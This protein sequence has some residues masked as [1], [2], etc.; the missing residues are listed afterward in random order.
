[1]FVLRS[2]DL[3][4]WA[5][6]VRGPPRY[7][8]VAADIW[9][10]RR[11]SQ[12]PAFAVYGSPPRELAETPAGA[13]QLSP[14]VPGAAA[15]EELAPG[16]LEAIV[17]AAP[18]GTIERRYVLALALRA[19]APGGRLTALAPKDKG[20]SRLGKELAAFGCTVHETPKRRQRICQTRRPDAPEGLDAAIEAGRPRLSDALGL[21]TWPGVFSWDRPDPGSVLLIQ[22]LPPLSGRGAD[23]GCGIGL[24][25]R[26]VL[27]QPTVTGLALVELDRRAIEC[28]RRNVVDPRATFHWQDARTGPELSGLDFVVM[29]PPFHD[30]GAE[31]KALGQAFIRR[32]HAILRPGGAL[33][34]VANRHLPYEGVLGELF[35]RTALAAEGAGFKVYEARK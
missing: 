29:N 28:A 12:D 22:S 13:V 9:N 27:A 30:G 10:F 23:L 18:P 1:M 31:D 16:R 32:A 35:A 5:V 26:A 19:L 3:K 21:W 33:W 14:L 6:D 20:G 2:Q 24:L 8:A 11:L 25:A 7:R 4:A 15:L 34:L 17:V